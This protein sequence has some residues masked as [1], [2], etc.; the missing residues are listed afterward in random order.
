MPIST[1]TRKLLWGRAANRCAICRKELSLAKNN[2]NNAIIGEECHIVARKEN[3]SRGISDLSIKQRDEYENL[4]L[5]CSNHHKS[6]DKNVDN[7]TVEKLKMT[8]VNH[9]RWV[10][11]TLNLLNNSNDWKNVKNPL[12]ELLLISDPEQVNTMQNVYE[13]KVE[14]S[15]KISICASLPGYARNEKFYGNGYLFSITNNS[16]LSVK[17]NRILANVQS[18]QKLSEIKLIPASMGGGGAEYNL[19]GCELVPEES[20]FECRY[21][22]EKYDYV[23]ITGNDI[24][25][26]EV[27]FV[28][29]SLRNLLYSI[30]LQ[31]YFTFGDKEY[32]VILSPMRVAFIVPSSANNYK[33]YF[34]E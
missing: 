14:N 25:C 1:R 7:Y 17:I 18:V 10:R 2:L 30:Q 34:L 4:I 27:Y 32:N 20:I 12:K 9:E 24:E 8:K 26:F 29:R 16:K 23:K 19:F 13:A 6:I 11:D 5:L 3:G 28:D 15:G 22:S 31:I 21:M 33:D